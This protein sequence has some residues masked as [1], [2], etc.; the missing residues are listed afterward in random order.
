GSKH[1]YGRAIDVYIING[2]GVSAGSPYWSTFLQREGNMGASELCGPASPYYCSGHDTHVHAGWT[3]NG[4]NVAASG[5]NRMDV[6]IRGAGDTLQ[7]KFWANNIWST[8]WTTEETGI[9]SDPTVVAWGPNRL[10]IFCQGADTQLKHK[11]WTGSVWSTGWEN[12]GNGFVGSPDACSWGVGRLDVFALSSTNTL[13]HKWWNGTLWSPTNGW[14]VE[15][16]GGLIAS[17]PTAISMGPDLIDVFARGTD[18]LMKHISFSKTAGWSAW[19]TIG[20]NTLV[21]GPDAASM[22][23]GSMDVFCRSTAGDLLQYFWRGSSW[24][25]TSQG[26]PAGLTL[27]S[28]PGATAYASNTLYVTARAS[29]NQCWRLWWDGSTWATWSSL[30]GGSLLGG[31]DICSWSNT[32]GTR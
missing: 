16:V 14:T 4:G 22:K 3:D 8:T 18:N 27:T 6:F 12:L 11:W 7:H 17:D 2:Y 5:C 23:N 19:S 28:D 20:T 30:L 13:L 32:A 26:L 10:D 31:P 15:G 29:D 21:G 24:V 1:Y 9:T 25:V